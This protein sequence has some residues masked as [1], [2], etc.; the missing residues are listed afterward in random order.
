MAKIDNKLINP[1]GLCE[2][3]CGNPAPIAKQT[4]SRL[5]HIKG[6]AVRFIRGHMFNKS[7]NGGHGV[8]WKGGRKKHAEGYIEIHMPSHPN[9]NKNGYVLEHVLVASKALGRKVPDGA[10]VHHTNGNRTDNRSRNL[11]ICDNR[12]YHRILHRREQALNN[13]GDADWRRC[14]YCSQWDAPKNLYIPSS[15]SGPRH[16]S[17]STNY[18]R[19]YK[20]KKK[21]LL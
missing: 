2:C 3:S 16:V 9:A 6:N 5:G 11:V 21:G 12:S 1:S 4:T 17:C 18:L 15:G 20:A 8:N 19:E 7:V 10:I 14:G 13:C